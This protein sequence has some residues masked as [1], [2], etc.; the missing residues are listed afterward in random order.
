MKK[1]CIIEDEFNGGC[2]NVSDEWNELLNF[3][4]DGSV[5]IEKYAELLSNQL[6]YKIE[7]NQLIEWLKKKKILISSKPCV[8][9]RKYI[10]KRWFTS[11]KVTILIGNTGNIAN[12]LVVSKEAQQQ[13]EKLLLSEKI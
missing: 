7:Y 12:G 10:K 6:G 11:R 3:G 13:I 2:I 5:G 1:I 8:P 4:V 9:Y